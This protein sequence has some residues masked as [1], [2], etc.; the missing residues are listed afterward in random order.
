MVVINIHTC[1]G[2]AFFDFKDP[3]LKPA[4]ADTVPG[5]MARMVLIRDH[6]AT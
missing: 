5:V 1:L 2:F 3:S 6:I 4:G